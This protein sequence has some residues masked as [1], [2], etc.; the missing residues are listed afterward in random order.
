[1]NPS[2]PAIVP[3]SMQV[4][5]TAAGDADT[6]AV[7]LFEGGT[8]EGPAAGLVDS[9]DARGKAG[10]TAVTHADGTRWIVVGL[11]PRDAWDAEAARVA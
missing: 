7:G 11:G 6:I 2:D 1:M 3:G 8:V 4:T 5:A 9:G 10:R